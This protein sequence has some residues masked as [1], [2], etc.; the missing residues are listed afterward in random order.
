MELGL[1]YEFGTWERDDEWT[2]ENGGR[3]KA[4]TR[5][6]EFGVFVGMYGSYSLFITEVPNE[7]RGSYKMMYAESDA[8]IEDTDFETNIP[9]LDKIIR[10]VNSTSFDHPRINTEATTYTLVPEE[11]IIEYAEQM[12]SA[13]NRNIKTA[14]TKHKTMRKKRKA[15]KKISNWMT[16]LP[17]LK[18]LGFT[19]GP[20]YKRAEKSFKTSFKG[21]TRKL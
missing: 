3:W 18:E 19:G 12:R 7:Y 14:R 16:I 1:V 11:D 21:R 20:L 15:G 4:I 9:I 17:P 8:P 2:Y 13:L 6:T 10:Y 5:D